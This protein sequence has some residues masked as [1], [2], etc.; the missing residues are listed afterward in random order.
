MGPERTGEPRERTSLTIER[1]YGASP[2]EVWRA[3]T[4]PRALSRWF[5]PENTGSVRLAE[6]DVRI[7]GRYRIA[8]NTTDG[9]EHEVS[10]TYREVH[11]LRKLTF[12]WAWRSTPERESLVSLAFH[13]AGTG[14]R[15]VFTH[16]QFFD[17]A[18][19]EGHA[20]GWSGAFHKL[21]RY[22]GDAVVS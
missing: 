6:L 10:G 12:T 22:L 11:P 7:G 8:F 20:R 15:L 2:E 3:W 14:T 18:A 21:D 16:D 1:T 5:G 17:E 19:R 9:E 4:D 13:P